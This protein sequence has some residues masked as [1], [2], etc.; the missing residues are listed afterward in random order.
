M[1]FPIRV[2]VVED[3]PFMRNALARRIA[4]DSRFEVVDTA[5]NGQEG[6]E[7]ALRIKPDVVT[8]D[9]EMPVMNGLEALKQIV[10]RSSIPVVMLSAVTLAGAKV[11]MEA[12]EIGAI[13][14]I[15]KAQG[16]ERVHETLLAAANANVKQS[17]ARAKPIR[18]PP[19]QSSPPARLATA[20]SRTDAKIIVVGSS[21]GGPQALTEII[22][23]LPANLP[24]PVVVAQHMPP[25]FTLALAK[26][27]DDVSRLKVM[28][29][30]DGEP[31][32]P[33]SVYIAP[34]GMHLRTAGKCIRVAASKGES[35]YHPSVDILAESVL[36]QYGKNVIGVMLTG[37]GNDGAREFTRLKQAGAHIIA[38]DQASCVVFGMPKSLIDAGG[39][40][41]VLSLSGIAERLRTLLAC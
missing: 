38:Q 14:F 2:L 41:E 1:A 40:T 13:D 5:E 19:V 29:A 10:S 3:S 12:L 26:R 6:V 35:L 31:L 34:G 23:H 27:L 17:A 39:A 24:V 9:V 7:K 32:S 22:Q 25:Q 33:G 18:M 15:P 37:M 20:A 16:A 36:E 21:T 8:L 30:K 11:T 4:S 28:E